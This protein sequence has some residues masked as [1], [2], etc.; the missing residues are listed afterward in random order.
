MLKAEKGF[1]E[2]QLNPTAQ[3]MENLPTDHCSQHDCMARAR[4]YK[5]S[6]MIETVTG[7]VAGAFSS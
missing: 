1:G 7:M 6:C 2:D 5:F 4:D 3:L